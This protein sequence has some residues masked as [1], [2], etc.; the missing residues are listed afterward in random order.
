MTA[1]G[2]VRLTWHGTV[3]EITLDRGER[4]NALTDEMVTALNVALR[5][6]A[7]ADAGTGLVLTGV[8]GSFCAGADLDNVR[9]AAATTSQ[10]KR[11]YIEAEGQ[12]IIRALLSLPV[13]TVA[14]VDGPAIGLGFDLALA[15][16]TVVIGPSGWC[17]QG[18]GRLGLV[19][20]TGGSL[21]LRSRNPRVLWRLL[22]EQPKID[23]PMGQELGIAEDAGDRSAREAA[24]ERQGRLSHLSR[25]ALAAYVEVQRHPVRA[26]LDGHLARSAR[27]QAELLTSAEFL[28]AAERVLTTAHP[29]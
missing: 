4:R 9:A 16:D 25:E 12:A 17:M 10:E 28:A 15:C 29:S 23:G 22:A 3:A 20:G 5:E 24:L 8:V 21:L 1:P 13:P 2:A 19:D 18:W 14:A 26:E 11:E 6:V 27:V 7:T